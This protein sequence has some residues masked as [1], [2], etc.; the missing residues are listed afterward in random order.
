MTGDS[1]ILTDSPVGKHID[2][3]TNPGNLSYL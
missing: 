2:A 1:T 3:I